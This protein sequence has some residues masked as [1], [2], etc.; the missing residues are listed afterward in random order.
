MRV[1]VRILDFSPR[2]AWWR[3]LAVALVT[4]ALSS[5][6]AAAQEGAAVAVA[7]SAPPERYQIAQAAVAMPNEDN[8]STGDLWK[9]TGIGA[10]I[11]AAAT[12]GWVGLQ[13]A[14]SDGEAIGVSPITVFVV[15]GAVGAVGGGLTGAL[16]CALAHPAPAAK[17]SP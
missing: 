14:H 16:A 10:L 17:R 12:A 3:A 2:I 5:V 9:W 11:G 7:M 15:A 4:T 6:G 1:T 13:M 8:W